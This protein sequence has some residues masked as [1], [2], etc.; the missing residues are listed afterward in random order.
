[1]IDPI[2]IALAELKQGI[3]E[4]RGAVHNQ[5]ILE[6]FEATSL[7]PFDGDETPWCA[8]FVN[9][10]HKQAW[11]E[12][13]NLANARSWLNWGEEVTITEV[14]VGDVVIFWRG[15]PTGWQGHVGFY[16]DHT[17]T[18]IYCLGGNQGNRVSIQ[19][20][21]INKVLGYRARS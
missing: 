14:Q 19:H 10:C 20:Y 2:D 18:N 9:W 21:D 5:R 15:S 6:Y 7:K 1:V 3:S 8:A 11:I 16:M 17:T 12:G 4:I 13:T